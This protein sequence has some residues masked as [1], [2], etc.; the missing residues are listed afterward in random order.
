[1]YILYIH[2]FVLCDYIDFEQYSFTWD[3]IHMI[4]FVALQMFDSIDLTAFL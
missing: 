2:L 4:N 3:I 1:M